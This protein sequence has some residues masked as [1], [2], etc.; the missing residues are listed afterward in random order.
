MHWA[1]NASKKPN[2][3]LIEPQLAHELKL[4]TAS[5]EIVIH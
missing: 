1:E 5:G 3:Y 4:S 2:N